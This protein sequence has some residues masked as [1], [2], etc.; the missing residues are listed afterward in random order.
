M[1]D[2]ISIFLKRLLLYLIPLYIIT[3]QKYST[4]EDN[5]FSDYNYSFDDELDKICQQKDYF[6][7]MIDAIKYSFDEL[8]TYS[9]QHEEKSLTYQS[10]KTTNIYCQNISA[11]FVNDLT[12]S[13]DE[14]GRYV[15][16]LINCTASMEGKLSYKGNNYNNFFSDI[17]LEKIRIFLN[18][19]HIKGEM[20]III[21][22]NKNKTFSYEKSSDIFDEESIHNMDKIM[23]SVFGN[24]TYNLG[25]IIEPDDLQL[26]SQIQ[27]FSDVIKQFTKQY[28]FLNQRIKSNE[29]KITYIAY[30]EFKYDS[31]INVNNHIYIPN[32]LINFEYTLNFNITYNEGNFILDYMNISKSKNDVYIGNIKNKSIEFDETIST[33]DR[34]QI[35]KDI[36]NDL[37]EKF[38][39]YKT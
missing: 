19:I 17:Y 35:W 14:G 34:E 24:Y 37:K 11:E 22:Y 18:K 8:K 21:D 6:C 7:I 9:Q 39:K 28:S 27:Y 10:V 13:L 36:K 2:F 1:K 20:H 3:N 25:N 31:L 32:L 4:C 33:E 38:L 30:N 16:S 15:L 29:S 12:E 26:L 5:S 23:E